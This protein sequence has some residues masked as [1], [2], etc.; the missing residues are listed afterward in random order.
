MTIGPA[1]RKEVYKDDEGHK[2][3]VFLEDGQS[4]HFILP[5]SAIKVGEEYL[6]PATGEW[7]AKE[8]K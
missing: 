6:D 8:K 5:P 7:R 1:T 3:E 4:N 2:I